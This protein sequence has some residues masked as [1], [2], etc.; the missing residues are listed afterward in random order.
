MPALACNSSAIPVESSMFW[1]RCVQDHTPVSDQIMNSSTFSKE[2][3][4]RSCTFPVSW[5]C[6]CLSQLQDTWA[7][8]HRSW[9]TKCPAMHVDHVTYTAPALWS[10]ATAY[11]AK[12]MCMH[13]EHSPERACATNSHDEAGCLAVS[14]VTCLCVCWAS[15]LASP[16]WMGGHDCR[17][18]EQQ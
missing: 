11:V 17:E 13:I 14:H 1:H 7:S 10:E 3:A 9:S 2:G 15:H 5:D 12:A 4:T 18:D 6:M 16:R 8:R